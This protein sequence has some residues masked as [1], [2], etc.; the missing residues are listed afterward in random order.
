M[1]KILIYAAIVTLFVL[2]QLAASIT[3]GRWYGQ[4][5]RIAT[6]LTITWLFGSGL[7]ALG[8]ADWYTL[9]VM[10]LLLLLAGAV[11]IARE[12]IDAAVA[13]YANK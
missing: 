7:A 1:T 10:G 6:V 5:V 11:R 2:A 13:S 3:I 9:I 8:T 12:R 4:N